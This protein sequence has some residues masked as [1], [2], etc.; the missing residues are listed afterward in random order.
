M[1]NAEVLKNLWVHV[2]CQNA[3]SAHRL[4][5]LIFTGIV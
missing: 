1:A 2:S 5:A 3:A 4:R